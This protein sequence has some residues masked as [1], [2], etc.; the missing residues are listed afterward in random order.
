MNPPLLL[1]RL[2]LSGQRSLRLRQKSL[3]SGFDWYRLVCDSSS[4]P[5]PHAIL[6]RKLCA[7]ERGGDGDKSLEFQSDKTPYKVLDLPRHAT[8]DQIRTQYRKL[9]RKYHPDSGSADASSDMMANITSAYEALTRG[10]SL[11]TAKDSRVANKVHG[12]YSIEELLDDDE[13]DVIQVVVRLDELLDGTD[14]DEDNGEEVTCSEDPRYDNPVSHGELG[15]GTAL[16]EFATSSVRVN[17][18]SFDSIADLKRSLQERYAAH[19]GLEGRRQSP[20]RLYIGWELVYDSYVLGENFFLRDYGI[21]SGDHLYAI[22][23]RS[24]VR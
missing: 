15:C 12:S 23:Q 20:E 3:S 9:V 22:I 5:S 18:T 8:P 17:T 2:F 4:F 11:Y 16:E 6:H 10:S 19:W 24:N 1:R 7:F 13:L 14:I 21:K